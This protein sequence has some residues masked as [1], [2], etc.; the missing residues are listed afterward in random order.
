VTDAIGAPPVEPLFLDGSA[1]RLFAVYHA[2]APGRVPTG[3][4][5]YLPPFAEEMNRSRRMAALQARA[6]ASSGIGVLLLDLYGTGDSGGEFVAA[7]WRI[8]LEDVA[9][10]AD[11]LGVRLP[12]RLGL[13]GLRLGGMLAAAAAAEAPG[14]FRRLMLWQPVTDGKSMLTQFL[15]LRVAAAM[16]GGEPKENTEQLRAE[17]T[18][19]RPLEVAGYEISPELAAAIDG[20]RL[21]DLDFGPDLAIDWLEIAPEAGR[22]LSPAARRVTEQWHERGIPIAAASVAGQQFWTTQEISLAPDLLAETHRRLLA[23]WV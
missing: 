7:R 2:P 14:R 4:L 23:D 10:A 11:W 9:T 1:G 21:N 13:L 8:W 3:G 12:A 15:R 18:A 5:I 17:L 6:L 19:G 22:A 16:G 20:L